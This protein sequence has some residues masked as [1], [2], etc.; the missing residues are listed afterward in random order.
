MTEV[1]GLFSA[2]Q[3]TQDDS[4]AEIIP[5]GVK[6]T[7]SQRLSRLSDTCRQI[8]RTAAAFGREFEFRKLARVTQEISED[9]LLE[10]LD[11]GL[12][13]RIIEGQPGGV[14]NYQFSHALIQQALA[15][16]VSPSRKARLHARIGEALEDL[17]GVDSD[18]Y[19]A[20]LTYHFT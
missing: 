2:A 10:A 8:L 7:I 17:Y 19:A 11:E 14:E 6:D 1:V 16:G 13:A 20:D 12:D 18:F 9:Q 5:E 15:L 3:M 4:W